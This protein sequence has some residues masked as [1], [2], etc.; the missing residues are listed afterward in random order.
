MIVWLNGEWVEDGAAVCAAGDRGLL[1]GDGLFETLRVSGGEPVRLAAHERRLRASC[2]ALGLAC[3]LDGI[4]LG[5]VIAELVSRAG[6][7]EAAIRLTLTAGAGER[8]LDRSGAAV[9]SCLIAAAPRAEPAP[10]LS[11]ATS[12]LRRAGSSIA[13]QHKTLSYIDNVM[14]RREAR[15]A[16]A[17]M[18]LALDTEGR[19]SGADCANLFWIR[20]GVLF[21]PSLECAVLPGTAR[22]T[23]IDALD[24]EQGRFAPVSLAGAD[25]V[26]VTNALL[27]AVAVT[28]IDGEP[29]GPAPVPDTVRALLD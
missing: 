7:Q 24:V 19:L 9:S 22:A 6:L 1:L 20:D 12:S 3:P 29:V 27:G 23:L 25:S 21:T 15:L 16:G 28:R 5:S 10:S 4:A 2:E 18:A 14:A 11:L 13:A 17:G 8:G 26:F